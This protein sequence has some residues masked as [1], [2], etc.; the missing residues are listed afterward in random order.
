MMATTEMEMVVHLLVM[1][2]VIIGVLVLL[3]YV[4]KFKS[5]ETA[6]LRLERTVTTETIRTGLAAMFDVK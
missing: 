2:K 3:Q 5:V 1:L 6:L 4:L